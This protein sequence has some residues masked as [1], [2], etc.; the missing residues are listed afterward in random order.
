MSSL[1]S[2]PGFGGGAAGGGSGGSGIVGGLL[3]TVTKALGGSGGGGSG[4]APMTAQ[5][6][7]ALLLSAGAGL[8]GAGLQPNRGKMSSGLLSAAGGGI[9]GMQAASLLGTSPLWSG[10]LGAG[11]G[12]TAAG[13]YKGGLGGLGMD[14]AGGALI[15]LQLGGPIGALIGAGVGAAAGGLRLLVKTADE[16]IRAK[17]KEVYGID[18]TEKNVRMQIAQI[19]HDRYGGN[20]NVAVASPE[21]QE[22]VRMYA[23]ATGKNPSGL[24]RPMYGATFTQ[25]GAGGVSLQPVYSGGNIVA[26]PYSGTTTTQYGQLGQQMTFLSLDPTQALSLLSGQVTGVMAQNPGNVA[27]ANAAALASGNS[28]DAQN[29]ALFEP[30]TVMS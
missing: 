8:L 22:I 6:G 29:N 12:L 10:V 20:I 7:N 17:V 11:I 26:N 25:S 13:L 2:V 9:L 28:R 15:G 30:L 14:V 4:G 3:G 24:P 18:I 21:V 23:I 16:K 19:A 27:S 5:I 1:G